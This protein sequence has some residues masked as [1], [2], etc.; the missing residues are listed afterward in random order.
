VLR[1]DGS[2]FYA[3]ITSSRIIYRERPCVI[4]FFRDVTERRQA[5]E[6]LQRERDALRQSLEAQDRDRKLIAYEIHDGLAQL[7]AGAI[8]QFQTCD[9]LRNADHELAV[10]ACQAGTDMIEN[11]LAQARQLM[12][13][14]RP[15]ILDEMG[16]VPAVK[17]LVNT[18]CGPG[19]PEVELVTSGS[20]DTLEKPLQ[21][22]VF[23]IVQESLTNAC[24]YS[25]SDKVRVEMA[26]REEAIRLRVEDWGVGFDPGAVQ[27]QCFGLAG[28]RQRAGVF[29][30]RASIE[31]AP[32]EG[33][34][35]A[36][37]LPCA[38]E[39]AVG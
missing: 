1:K 32:G 28:I 36:V 39:S 17:H 14:L 20:F 27:E 4:G 23:R 3:D 19:S 7:L 35:I 11:C 26:R 10:R 16:V 5:Q 38:V 33:T 30:G 22:C 9:Q 34:R 13:D 21:N 25:K 29:G 8:M 24:R 6:A 37:R 31:T 18:L 12:S 15:L 2:V